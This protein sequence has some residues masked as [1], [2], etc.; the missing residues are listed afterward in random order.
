[1]NQAGS[2]FWLWVL[3]MFASLLGRAKT[4]TS[5]AGLLFV[6]FAAGLVPGSWFLVPGSW[7]VVLVKI[8]D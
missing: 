4:R 2:W 5:R 1:M 6:F 3:V 8:L 7:F